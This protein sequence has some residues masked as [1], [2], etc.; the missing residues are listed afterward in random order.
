MGS[1]VYRW[2]AETTKRDF[3]HTKCF[4]EDDSMEDRY[5]TVE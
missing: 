1:N 2:G 5:G 3:G 4:V